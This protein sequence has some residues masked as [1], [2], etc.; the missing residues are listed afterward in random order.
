MLSKGVRRETEEEID[1]ANFSLFDDPSQPY[2][3]TNFV[4]DP[5][6]YDRLFKLIE[7][8]TL[9]NIDKIKEEICE[10]VEKK[11]EIALKPA[12]NIIRK[13]QNVMNACKKFQR[14]GNMSLKVNESRRRKL[15]AKCQAAEA[16]SP[17]SG[18]EASPPYHDAYED[19]DKVDNEGDSTDVIAENREEK[20][21]KNIFFNEDSVNTDCK[22]IQDIS[23]TL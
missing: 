22:M 21:N 12:E 9:S 16:N 19:L 5:L 14:S 10:C 13:M 2:A 4:Y 11:R 15:M 6:Q 20:I 23:A 8:N 18:N 7:F 17:L 3:S 1:F